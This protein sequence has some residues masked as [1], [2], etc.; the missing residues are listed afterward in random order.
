MPTLFLLVCWGWMVPGLDS[1]V[2][3]LEE[4]ANKD[5]DSRTPTSPMYCPRGG[6]LPLVSGEEPGADLDQ[7]WHHFV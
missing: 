6:T 3:A 7:S 4:S 1:F 5:E 2:L